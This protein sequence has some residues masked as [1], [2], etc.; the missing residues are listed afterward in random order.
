MYVNVGID[1]GSTTVKMVL[2]DERNQTCFSRY[3]RHYADIQKAAEKIIKEAQDEIDKKSN[4]KQI[5]EI[6]ALTISGAVLAFFVG[7]FVNQITELIDFYKGPIKEI[8]VQL[9]WKVSIVLLGLTSLI[10]VIWFFRSALKVINDYSEKG[11]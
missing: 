3:E 10:T 1:I 5:Q 6:K 11:S 9:T 7:L 2:L 8:D 4:L